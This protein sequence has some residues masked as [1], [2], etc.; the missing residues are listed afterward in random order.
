MFHTHTHPARA[1]FP[2]WKKRVTYDYGTNKP[3]REYSAQ[4]MWC[5]QDAQRPMEDCPLLFSQK[6]HWIPE[7][8]WRGEQS[9]HLSCQDCQRWCGSLSKGR[10]HIRREI[11]LH[12]VATMT[13]GYTKPVPP[14]I[15]RSFG[16]WPVPTH[17]EEED[18]LAP[19]IVCSRFAGSPQSKVLAS[20]LWRY[21]TRISLHVWVPDAPQRVTFRKP[22][23]GCPY[24][25]REIEELEKSDFAGVQIQF[26]HLEVSWTPV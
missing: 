21:K 4:S 7:C 2:F 18:P 24:C 14:V 13:D 15:S 9:L 25:H 1:G 16:P 17:S 8:G 23:P 12:R 6:L 22:P 20:H 5:R 11:V 3:V 10:F 26:D 19:G